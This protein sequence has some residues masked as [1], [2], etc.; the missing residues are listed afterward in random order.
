MQPLYG[1]LSDIFGRYVAPS[2][3]EVQLTGLYDNLIRSHLISPL[4]RKNTILVAIFFFLLGSLICG[5][6]PTIVILVVGRGIAGVGAGGMI[7]L[8]MI[9]ISDVVSLRERGYVVDD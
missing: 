5:A 7:S 8:T 6:A 4:N 2:R 1:K 9:I 3:T